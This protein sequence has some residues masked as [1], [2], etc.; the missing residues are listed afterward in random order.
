MSED[1]ILVTGASGG[2][3]YEFARQL[4][5]AGC[6]FILHAR[7]EVRLQLTLDAL[8][9]PERHR[10]I[11]ADLSQRKS[12]ENFIEAV[13]GEGDLTGLINNAG[14]GVWGKFEQCEDVAQLDVLRTD[15]IAP[16]AITHALLPGL[17]RKRGFIINVSSLAG[18][19]P[20]PYMSIYAAAK[21]GM[22]CW[23]EA[24]RIELGGRVRVVTLVPGPSPTGFRDVSGA[25]K[26]KGS[27]FRA[28]AEV[29]VSASLNRLRQGGGY[30][31]PGFRHNLLWLLQKIVPR[32]VA[33][34]LM[35]RHLR[36]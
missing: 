24:L 36:P 31:V 11:I 21:A 9:E 15:L 18:E 17:I 29:V 25:P 33:L 4:E 16:V 26:G 5:S 30:C 13:S 22:T 8:K 19:M 35:D 14:F 32:G 2:F 28:S 27:L 23:S 10:T 12:V 3:G 34:R 1:I 20:L 7:D 6:R